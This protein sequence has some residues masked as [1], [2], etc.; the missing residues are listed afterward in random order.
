MTET[1]K[2]GRGRPKGA[3]NKP[4]LELITK[5]TELPKDADAYEILCQAEIVAQESEDLAAQGLRVFSERNGAVK[6]IIQW[7]FDDNINS[8]L[9]KGKTPYN[10]DDAPASDL[11]QTSL[12]FEF[13]QF[14]YF[15]TEEVPQSRRETMWIQLLEGIPQM[16]AELLELVKDGVWPFK[17]ITKD[18]A[19]K[20]FPEVIK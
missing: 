3:P 12:R 13:R 10:R 4:K 17:N 19:Q 15:V 9:P 6:Q 14:K 1:K 5:R 11:A 2:K 8:T 18:V 16:E 20:A 7:V